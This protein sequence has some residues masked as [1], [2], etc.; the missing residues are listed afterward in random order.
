MKHIVNFTTDLIVHHLKLIMMV[1][2]SALL[3]Q[4]DGDQVYQYGLLK[5]DDTN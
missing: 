2:L 5:H 4:V 3:K 1:C